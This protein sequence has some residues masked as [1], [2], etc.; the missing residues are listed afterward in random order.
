MNLT[1]KVGKKSLQQIADNI[2]KV[3]DEAMTTQPEQIPPRGTKEFAR[4]AAETMMAGAAGQTIKISMKD[5]NNFIGDA[6]VSWDW[7]RF[8]YRIAPTPPA[9]TR[10]YETFEEFMLLVPSHGN[11]LVRRKSDGEIS[12]AYFI[13]SKNN[14]YIHVHTF[15][16]IDRSN[17]RDY[18]KSLDGGKSWVDCGVE[19]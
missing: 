9:K 17:F 19:E 15:S 3:L 1:L 11:F 6:A 16:N 2:R 12:S 5:P 4:Y 13:V 10:R 7:D 14:T 18:K 8:D